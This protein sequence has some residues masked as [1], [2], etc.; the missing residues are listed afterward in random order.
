M[1]HGPINIKGKYICCSNG[2]SWFVFFW[3]S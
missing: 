3:S 1:M 2:G